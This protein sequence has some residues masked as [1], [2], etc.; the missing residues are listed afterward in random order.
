MVERSPEKAGV[1]GSIPSLATSTFSPPFR[2][3]CVQQRDAGPSL[4]PADYTE[5]RIGGPT[6]DR[7]FYLQRQNLEL[8]IFLNVLRAIP[9]EQIQYKPHERSPSAEQ[10]V[11]TLASE[12]AT[13]VRAVTEHRGEWRHDQPPPLEEMIALFARSSH[14]LAAQVAQMDDAAWARNAQFFHNGQMVSEMPVCDFL[15]MVLFDA[16][17]HRGQLSAYLRPMGAKVP[18]IYGPSADER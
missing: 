13:C 14:D 9:K 8:P 7:D 11:W 15:W 4:L 17:H 16:I 1:G 10:L 3:A 12:M 5:R 18:K 6:M 2:S